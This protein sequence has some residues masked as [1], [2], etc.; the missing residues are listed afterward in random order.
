MLL[1]GSIKEESQ[2][3]RRL[4]GLM[5]SFANTKTRSKGLDLVLLKKL[6]KLELCEFSNKRKCMKDN[7]TC[8]IIRLLTLIKFLLLLKASKMLNKL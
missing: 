6:S 8:S 5:L 4:R 2:W 7:V 3:K 1:I